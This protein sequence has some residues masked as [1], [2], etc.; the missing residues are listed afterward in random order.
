VSE[1]ELVQIR[2]QMV[3]SAMLMDALYAALEDAEKALNRVRRRLAVS[4]F[5]V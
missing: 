5:A 3:L 1:I 4:L 2:L